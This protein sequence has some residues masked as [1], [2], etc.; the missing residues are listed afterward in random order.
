MKTAKKIAIISSDITLQCQLKSYLSD[1]GHSIKVVQNYAEELDSVV[2]SFGPD[3]YIVDPEAPE[4]TGVEIGLHLRR[5]SATPILMLSSFRTAKNQLRL[6]DS[7]SRDF[8]GRPFGFPDLAVRIDQIL[9]LNR[10]A[11]GEIDIFGS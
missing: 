10:G 5:I 11:S 7:R 6:L 8:L 1:M 3:L 4:M 2:E 9:S